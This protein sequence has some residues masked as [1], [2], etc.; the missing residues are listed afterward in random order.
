MRAGDRSAGGRCLGAL[1]MLFR[2]LPWGLVAKPS[3]QLAKPPLPRL[4]VTF[5]LF[6]GKMKPHFLKT[7]WG[8]WVFQ[9]AEQAA[10]PQVLL[11][12]SAQFI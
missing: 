1:A 6:S 9:S 11:D 2:R 8:T 5:T 12:D 10:S 3:A 4:R 7:E